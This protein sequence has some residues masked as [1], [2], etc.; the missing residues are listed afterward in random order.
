[1]VAFIGAE[2]LSSPRNGFRFRLRYRFRLK[3]PQ[4]SLGFV[5]EVVEA[6]RRVEGEFH[7]DGLDTFDVAHH[8]LDLAEHVFSLGAVGRRHGHEDLDVEFVVDVNLV[9]ESEVVDVDG[10]LGVVDV[11]EAV[12][13][14]TVDGLF[15]GLHDVVGFW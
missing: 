11:L 2:T 12:D 15:V 3:K 6:P 14:C 1:M 10:N 9:D 4:L 8:F 13:D 5:A 7:V